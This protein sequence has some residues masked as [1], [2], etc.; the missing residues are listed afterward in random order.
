MDEISRC[1]IVNEIIAHAITFPILWHKSAED[2]WH[3]DTGGISP[4]SQSA[5]WR[6][7][8]LSIKTREQRKSYSDLLRKITHASDNSEYRATRSKAFGAALAACTALVAWAECANLLKL[9]PDVIKENALTGDHQAA[10]LYPAVLVMHN[11]G[12]R[13]GQRTALD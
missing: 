6:A 1:V 13:D 7:A 11:N 8:D 10:M 12:E 4:A 5:A 3:P 9:H 2:A